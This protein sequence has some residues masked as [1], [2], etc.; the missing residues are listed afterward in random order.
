MI[1][2]FLILFN[3]IGT[4]EE[5]FV[6]F[7]KVDTINSRNFSIHQKCFEKWS[8]S[9]R[10]VP[11]YLEDEFVGAGI[12]SHSD[13]KGWIFAKV[14]LNRKIESEYSLRMNM[15]VHHCEFNENGCYWQINDSEITKF[16][17]LR[18]ASKY[19]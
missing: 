6:P 9:K 2:I 19:E 4:K 15:K 13:E 17:F 14:F 7:A 1:S 8:K 3:L 10:F 16:V 5:I 12:C 18:N 11:I